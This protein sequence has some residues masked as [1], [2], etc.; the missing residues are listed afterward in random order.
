MCDINALLQRVLELR[1]YDFN[2][3][4]I[5]LDMTMDSRMPRVW[6]DPDQVQQVFFNLIK[7]GEQ[8]MIDANGGGKLTVDNRATGRRDGS[9]SLM[10]AP[11]SRPR[12]SAASSTPFSRRRTR[13][14]AP[15]SA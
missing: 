13:G 3:R 2:I 4:N 15:A 9:Q 10:T 14:R 1:S 6:V 11:V 7:N 8:A 5:S 12:S